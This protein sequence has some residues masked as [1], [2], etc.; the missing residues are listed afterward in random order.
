MVPKAAVQSTTYAH[1]ARCPAT[2]SSHP[3]QSHIRRVF[4]PQQIGSL[5]GWSRDPGADFPIHVAVDDTSIYIGRSSGN[6]V[7][8]PVD[9]AFW[10][11]LQPIPEI[12]NISMAAE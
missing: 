7:R 3:T 12:A 2:S 11:R 9:A 4:D 1:T 5:N 6:H 10:K 8:V